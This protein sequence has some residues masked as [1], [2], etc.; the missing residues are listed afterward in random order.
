M[1]LNG[2]VATQAEY[3]V[4]SS[5]VSVLG[6]TD[7]NSAQI[8]YSCVYKLKLDTLD[9]RDESF[10]PLSKSHAPMV[11]IFGP[12]DQVQHNSALI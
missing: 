12:K 7:S 5:L 9:T 11:E 4:P 6:L 2:S 10:I 8:A 1:S 3:L